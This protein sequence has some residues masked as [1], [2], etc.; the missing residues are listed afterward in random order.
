MD[1]QTG[2]LWAALAHAS[3]LLNM[4]TGILGTLAVLILY[5]VTR[6][7]SPYVAF[8]ALQALAYQLIVWLGGWALALLFWLL[9]SALSDSFFGLLVMVLA[10]LVNLV[11]L[12]GVM[13]AGIGALDLWRG[14][15]F[16]YPKIGAWALRI[17]NR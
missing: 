4:I 8:H 1:Q 5:L 16:S 12:I 15:E 13:F 17:V 9:G 6:R 2:R 7:R 11:P 14:Q 10:F 3:I